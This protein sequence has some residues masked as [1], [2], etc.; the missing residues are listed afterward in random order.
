MQDLP[1]RFDDLIAATGGA[2]AQPPY[3]GL[4]AQPRHRWRKLKFDH[5]GA[6][7]QLWPHRD[8]GLVPSSNRAGFFAIIIWRFIL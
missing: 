7:V 5:D 2:T 3:S 1:C 4:T 6:T 8:K